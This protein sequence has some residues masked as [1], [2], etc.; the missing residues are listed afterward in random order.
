VLQ[1]APRTP[2][3]WDRRVAPTANN[4]PADEPTRRWRERAPDTTAEHR[5][6]ASMELPHDLVGPDRAD[7]RIA[8]VCP[9]LRVLV[10]RP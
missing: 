1:S 10:G 3:G 8:E 7:Q 2:H 4:D 6:P 9:V 5:F